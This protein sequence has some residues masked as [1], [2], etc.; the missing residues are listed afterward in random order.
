LHRASIGTVLLPLAALFASASMLQWD[1]I[2][3][4]ANG[5]GDKGPWRQN[6][7]RYDYVDDA[8]VAIAANGDFDVAWVDQAR[9]DIFFQALMPDGVPRTAPI[10]ISRNT[11]TF[12][13]LPRIVAMPGVPGKV[14][15]LWQEIIFS[16]G[17]HGGDIL[18]ARSVDGG[19][20]FSEP[21]NLSNSSGGDGKGRLDRD[22]WSNGSLDLAAG[23]DGTLYAAWTEYDGMLWL[24]RSVNGGASFSQPQQIAGN[25]ALPA[26]GPS[27]ATGPGRTV[28]LAWTVG[29]DPAA[30]IR[31]AQSDDGGARFSRPHIVGAAPGHADAPRLALD[32]RGVLHLV[33]AESTNGAKG[34]Y[35]IRYTR[36]SDGAAG[37]EVPRTLPALTQQ[38][39][40]GAACPEVAMD[41]QGVL[42]VMW[43]AFPDA[44]AGPRGLAITF[45]PDN[46]NTF[47]LPIL[48]PGSRDGGGGTN[49][50][51]QG[52]LGKK[53]AVSRSG[54]IAVVNS[55]LKQNDRSRVW[56]MRGRVMP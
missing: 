45:S 26:R 6:D 31:V 14:Y 3:E 12:S 1:P 20:S 32:S 39:K 27:L 47:A 16:G 22:T 42:Y 40:G 44:T 33:Y 24:A 54:R 53:L 30:D 48:V 8:T 19:I 52:L 10:N 9:K 2:I 36:S 7:S 43:E 5:R 49:G 15:L 35:R 21:I 28:Y 38:D 29:E 25:R 18:F 51:H 46:G 4:L 23:P 11:A 17:S 13:W 34:P 37:F 50:S 56:L 41:G 55:S